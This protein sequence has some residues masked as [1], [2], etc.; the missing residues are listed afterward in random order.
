[1]ENV[2]LK[3][4]VTLKRKSND[5]SQLKSK[6][7]L[8]LLLLAMVAI[9]AILCVKNCSSNG[10]ENAGTTVEQPAVMPTEETPNADAEG[11][12]DE[13]TVLEKTATEGTADETIT[14]QAET[15]P[16]VSKATTESVLSTQPD[17]K[18][19]GNNTFSILQGNLEEKALRV[20]RGDFGNGVERK[21]ALGSEYNAIQQ[22]VNEMYREGIVY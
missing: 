4:K 15:T 6:W 13:T 9:V 8:W 17:V 11:I 5:T 12:T 21:H 19:A 1:M 22:R 3:R 2:E 10:D 16:A 20:I 14:P 7:W 18:T